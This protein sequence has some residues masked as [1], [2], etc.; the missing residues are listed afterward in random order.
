[1]V[2]YKAIYITQLFVESFIKKYFVQKTMSLQTYYSQKY[3]AVDPLAFNKVPFTLL[4]PNNSFLKS[5][6]RW[7]PY[8]KLSK[9]HA[10]Y[11]MRK[12]SPSDCLY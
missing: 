1:M 3:E 4:G 9:P 2:L 11:T 10:K 7:L 8:T 6:Q 5:L 12:L